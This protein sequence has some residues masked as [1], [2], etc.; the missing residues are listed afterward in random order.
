MILT[1][2]NHSACSVL[3]NLTSASKTANIFCYMGFHS[4]RTKIIP[5]DVLGALGVLAESILSIV[6]LCAAFEV[7]TELV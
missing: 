5:A 2:E 1:T 7:N 4:V 6:V 3:S